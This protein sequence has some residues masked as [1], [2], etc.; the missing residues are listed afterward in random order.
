MN[1]IANGVAV[2]PRAASTMTPRATSAVG[3]TTPTK[4]NAGKATEAKSKS[5]EFVDLSTVDDE[6][7]SSKTTE[8]K[9]EYDDEGIQSNGLVSI[10]D[11]FAKKLTAMRG[12][13]ALSVFN[14]QWLR[15]DLLQNTLRSRSTKEKL[16]DTYIGLPVPVEWKMTFSDW[17]IAFDLFVAY[18]RYYK[19]GRLADRFMVHK[20]N[21]FAIQ[22]ENFNW[23]MAFRYDIAIR[24][25][26]MTF[27][28]ENGKIA[29]PAIRNE[30]YERDAFRETERLKDF[31]PSFAGTNPYAEGEVKRFIN[32]LS[33]L[34]NRP[35]APLVHHENNNNARKPN[36]RSW[37]HSNQLVHEGPGG[38]NYGEWEDRRGNGRNVRGRGRGGGYNV[39]TG[40]N[41]DDNRRAEG[42]GS[43]RQDE[44][45][46]DRR[47]NEDRRGGNDRYGRNDRYGGNGKAK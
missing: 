21:V 46:E 28:N 18:L 31:S 20:E 39:N 11:Y 14:A 13:I 29:N 35:V 44:R 6:E 9:I 42:S 47:G 22:R 1:T 15:E 41:R 40:G 8:K 33:G 25:I 27:R 12:Y 36:A 7:S 26:V 34:D 16:E 24:T 45:R 3:T 17:V 19:H 4:S 2:T 37:S 32:P 43:W 38:V 30:K 10:S 23:P 5:V